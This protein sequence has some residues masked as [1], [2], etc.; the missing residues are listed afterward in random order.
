MLLIY[1]I[2]SLNTRNF[3]EIYLDLAIHDAQQKITHIVK[4]NIQGI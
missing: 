3:F 2:Y 4:V 1:L